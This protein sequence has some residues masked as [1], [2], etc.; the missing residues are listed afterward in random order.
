MPFEVALN[1]IKYYGN[2]TSVLEKFPPVSVD[3]DALDRLK[4][5]KK[6]SKE[7]WVTILKNR[8]HT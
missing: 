5:I 3:Q 7:R 6:E 1:R 8:N 4:K 2:L